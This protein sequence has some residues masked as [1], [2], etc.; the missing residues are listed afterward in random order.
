M[1]DSNTPTPVPSGSSA[2]LSSPSRLVFLGS[3]LTTLGGMGL[4]GGIIWRTLPWAMKL[5]EAGDMKPLLGICFCVGM[6]V[7]PADTLGLLKRLAPGKR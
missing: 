1:T 2:R 6:L 7:A 3:A 4:L 5:Y